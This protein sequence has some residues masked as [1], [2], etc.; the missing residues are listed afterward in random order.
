MVDYSGVHSNLQSMFSDMQD[1]M[2]GFFPVLM[3]MLSPLPSVPQ[4]FHPS[5]QYICLSTLSVSYNAA[6][7][8]C[9]WLVERG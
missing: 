6:G 3:H 4:I 5:I 7:E 2:R 8:E 1:D 9:G